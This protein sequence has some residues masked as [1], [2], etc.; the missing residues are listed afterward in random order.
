MKKNKNTKVT[1]I[2]I[3][4]VASAMIIS[5][6]A[7]VFTLG[8]KGSSD[9]TK[10][11]TEESVKKEN[12]KNNDTTA[13]VES[14]ITEDLKQDM[15]KAVVKETATEVTAVINV[16]KTVTRIQADKMVEEYANTLKAKYK[17]KTIKVQVVKNKEIIAETSAHS[18]VVKE[19]GIPPMD[20]KI[21]TGITSMD[22]YIEITL[23]TDK[24][25][26]YNIQVM[27]TTLKY[28][29]AKKF[30]HGVIE[31]TDENAIK[32]N[33]KVALKK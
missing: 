31:S 5:T 9:K 30:F 11:V 13:K 7:S 33:I 24:P 14:T 21:G 27:G 32:N 1:K 3:G 25:E 17:G 26:Q 18:G 12:E 4:I 6:V 2:I 28:V 15:A 19:N 10:Q 23:K 16:T 20:V 22:R 29:P 8:N